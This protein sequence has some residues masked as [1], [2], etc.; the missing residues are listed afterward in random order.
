MAERDVASDVRSWPVAFSELVSEV[1]KGMTS[2]ERQEAFV[3]F[4]ADAEK[5]L[6]DAVRSLFTLLLTLSDCN[7]RLRWL[8]T[9]AMGPS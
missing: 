8:T 1:E 6:W 2:K 7:C 9:P 4:M 3:G 5:L